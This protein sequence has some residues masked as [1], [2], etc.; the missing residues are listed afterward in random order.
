MLARIEANERERTVMLAG[1]PHDL[2]T[3]IS[4]LKV[5]AEL[6]EDREVREGF[7]RDVQDIEHISQQFVQYLRGL[8]GPALERRPLNLV[9]LLGER[10]ERWVKGDNDVRMTAASGNVVVNGNRVALERLTDNLIGNAIQHGAPPIEIEVARSDAG[11]G[12]RAARRTRSW[13]WHSRERA[14]DSA[15]AVYSTERGAGHQG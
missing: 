7:R 14:V 5:R 11:R 3:P 2:R 6:V 8:D 1:L 15:R 10:V 13:P 12:P 9:G 4:R